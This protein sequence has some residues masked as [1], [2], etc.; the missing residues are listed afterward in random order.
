MIATGEMYSV[1]DFLEKAFGYLQLDWQDYVV[2]D[3]R[4]I[5]PTEVDALCGDATKA[6][7]VLGWKPEINFTSLVR[8]MVDAEISRLN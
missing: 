1:R 2:T 3:P 6:R 8:E 5:R 7:N 4:Y